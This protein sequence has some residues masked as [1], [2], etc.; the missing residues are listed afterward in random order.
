MEQP[1]S[2]ICFV[3]NKMQRRNRLIKEK[4]EYDLISVTGDQNEKKENWDIAFGLQ[5]V[6]DLEPSAYMYELAVKH[7][8][9]DI[10]LTEI[11]AL[12]Y[13]RYENETAEELVNRTKEC[14]LVAT[15]INEL[16][17]SKSFV[18]SPVTLKVIHGHLFKGLYSHAGQY[19][20]QNFTKKEAILSGHTVVYGDAMSI[21]ETLAY[22]FDIEKNTKYAK[23]KPDEVVKRICN[24]T[25]SIWQVHPFEEGNTRTTAVF[26]ERYLQSMGFKVDND[27]LKQNSKYFRNALVR[28]NYSDYVN[29]I[30]TNSEFLEYFFSNILLGAKHALKNRDLIVTEYLQQKKKEHKF[31]R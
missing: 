9:G 15:R 18:F 31:I 14:D 19:K 13:A 17:L 7:I 23:M 5:K 29:G 21:E 24:F 16:L 12:L 22:D 1:K 25:S 8:R 3:P 20:T 26:I 27:P 11:E 4:N 30:D 10:D 2:T 28:S 6:D